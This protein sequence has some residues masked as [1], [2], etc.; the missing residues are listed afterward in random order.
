VLICSPSYYVI[1]MEGEKGSK[2]G[3]RRRDHFVG[4]VPLRSRDFDVRNP[5]T[6]PPQGKGKEIYYCK[7]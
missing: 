2:N 6:T 4:S 5:G 3:R 1:K 7:G